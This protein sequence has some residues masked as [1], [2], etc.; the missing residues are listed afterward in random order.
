[1]TQNGGGASAP[2]LLQCE[3]HYEPNGLNDLEGFVLGQRYGF[4]ILCDQKTNKVFIRLYS[5]DRMYDTP[6][7][8]DQ[9]GPGVFNKYFTEVER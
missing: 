7:F 8:M 5:L 9:C 6:Q 1:M 4:R 2:P 3:C